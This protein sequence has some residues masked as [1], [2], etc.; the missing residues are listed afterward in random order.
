MLRIK[1]KYFL[2]FSLILSG[3]VSVHKP[4]RSYRSFQQPLEQ[5]LTASIGSSLLRMNRIGDLPNAYGGRDI[6]GGKVD[7]GFVDVKLLAISESLELTMSVHDVAKQTTE[8]TMDRYK[9]AIS[10][11]QNVNNNFNSEGNIFKINGNTE[12]E[13]IIDGIKIIFLEIRKSSVVYKLHD[14]YPVN[15]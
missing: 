4:I 5:T 11:S 12:K 8:T 14:L 10:V 6:Y 2:I 9:D 1:Q 13:Y 15:N 3:C 7:K